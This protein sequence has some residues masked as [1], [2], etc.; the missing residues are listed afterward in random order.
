MGPGSLVKAFI[1]C[2]G[3]G[4][5]LRTVIGESQKA[6]AEVAGKPFLEFV[7]GALVRAGL[8]DLVFCT[9][10]QSEQVEQVVAHLGGDPRLRLEVVREP[11]PLGTG[12]AVVHAMRSLGYQGRLLALNADTYLDAQAYRAAAQAEPPSMLVTRVDDCMRYGAVQVDAS[13]HVT[14]LQE[15]G[16]QGPGLISAGVYSLDSD[17]LGGFAPGQL[18]MEKD[19]LPKLVSSHR[20]RAVVYAGPFVDIGTPESLRSMRAMGI[21]GP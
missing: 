14:N 18:S 1:L 9:H 10:Y 13:M 19:V 20:L 5:R 16:T 12:G 4:T 11:E 7:V 21:Q 17:T 2:G 15:K 8:T 3:F 6:V